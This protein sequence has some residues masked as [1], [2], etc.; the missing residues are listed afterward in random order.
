MAHKD[1]HQDL[2]DGFSEILDVDRVLDEIGR[3]DRLDNADDRILSMLAAARAEADTDIPAAPQ[4]AD[5]LGEEYAPEPEGT[6]EDDELAKKRGRH[7]IGRRR[8]AAATATA[9]GVSISGMLLAGAAAATIAVGGL[10][11]AAYTNFSQ[12]KQEDTASTSSAPAQPSSRASV[13]PPA[14][15]PVPAEPKEEPTEETPAEESTKP[16]PEPSETYVAEPQATPQTQAPNTAQDDVVRGLQDP[17]WTEVPEYSQLQDTLAD[18]FSTN[19]T[20]PTETTTT[21]TTPPPEEPVIPPEYYDKMW[22]PQGW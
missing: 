20:E 19:T 15:P 8:V 5:L 14:A 21:T 11:Y 7:R 22:A 18:P 17:T 10:G 4:L 6:A 3:G 12:P 9:G 2:G 1:I 13:Q 16:E